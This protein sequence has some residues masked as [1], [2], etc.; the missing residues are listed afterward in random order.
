MRIDG[1]VL[2]P[3]IDRLAI[4][5]DHFTAVSDDDVLDVLAGVRGCRVC[6]VDAYSLSVW[7][8]S[9]EAESFT[10]PVGYA[11]W[12]VVGDFV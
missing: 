8:G 10:V 7:V 3:P 9:E 4:A 12:L 1:V 11:G 6:L 5:S 2:D